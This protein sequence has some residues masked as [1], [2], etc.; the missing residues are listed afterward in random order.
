MNPLKIT[1]TSMH[2]QKLSGLNN[3][4]LIVKMLQMPTDSSVCSIPR[5]K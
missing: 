2:S 5:G 4:W 3:E 1:V